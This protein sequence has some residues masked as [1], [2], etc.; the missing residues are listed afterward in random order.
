MARGWMWCMTVMGNTHKK[1]I[2]TNGCEHRH[3]KE[4]QLK[5][6]LFFSSPI[7]VSVNVEQK[8]MDYTKQ[9]ESTRSAWRLEGPVVLQ[10]H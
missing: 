3:R 7:V 10:V 6:S 1:G 2:H 5:Y 8:L 4:I 9:L